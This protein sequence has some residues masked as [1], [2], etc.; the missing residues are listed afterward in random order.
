M[1]FWVAFFSALESEVAEVGIFATLAPICLVFGMLKLFWNVKFWQQY[2]SSQFVG[3]ALVHNLLGTKDRL[4]QIGEKQLHFLRTF[5]IKL[6]VRK[7]KSKLSASLAYILLWFL[8][9]LTI[10][11]AK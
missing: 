1:K 9:Q 10:L 7:A 2:L 5:E 4:W 8:H 3:F 6:V 11:Y